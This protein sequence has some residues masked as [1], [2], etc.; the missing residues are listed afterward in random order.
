M[1]GNQLSEKIS[2][3]QARESLLRSQEANA[4]DLRLLMRWPLL[5]RGAVGNGR[6]TFRALTGG[7][8][9]QTNHLIV[10][11]HPLYFFQPSIYGAAR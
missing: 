1:T 4:R 2:A 3:L 5:P 10:T 8:I 7:Q 9:L 6:Q 11:D